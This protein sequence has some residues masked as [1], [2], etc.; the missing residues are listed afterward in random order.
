MNNAT[1]R[2]LIEAYVTSL[3]KDQRFTSTSVAEATGVYYQAV[4]HHF[5]SLRRDG[6]IKL[7]G[8]ERPHKRKR[9]VYVNAR[10]ETKISN[11]FVDRLASIVNT[12]K[13]TPLSAYSDEELLAEVARRAR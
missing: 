13:K 2:E 7:V 4:S 5:T 9:F 1:H 3:P 10:A 11:K 6:V 12:S 8:T